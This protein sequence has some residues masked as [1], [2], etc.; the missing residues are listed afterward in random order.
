M[1][2]PVI[3]L[4]QS[5]TLARAD[6]YTYLPHIGLYVL[7]VWGAAD[8]LRQHRAAAALCAGVA[9]CALA[10]CGYQQTTYWKDS[11]ALWTHALSC[12]QRNSIAHDS[13]GQFLVEKGRSEEAY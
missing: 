12:T 13:L 4:I 6:R 9:L 11:G 5:G 1:L 10:V 8:L 3:G 7:S 2:V